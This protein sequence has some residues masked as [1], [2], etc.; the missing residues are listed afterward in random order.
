MLCFLW[1]EFKCFIEYYFQSEFESE[2]RQK[3]ATIMEKILTE[4][5]RLKKRKKQQ[6]HLWTDAKADKSKVV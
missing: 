4:E 3:Q 1:L 5:E 6:P 2:K